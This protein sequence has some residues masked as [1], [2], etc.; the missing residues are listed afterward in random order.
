MKSRLAFTLAELL[1]VIAIMGLLMALILPAIQAARESGR[2]TV[3]ASNLAQLAKA[4][5]THQQARDHMP[6]YY[7]TDEYIRSQSAWYV[8]L[9]PYL[10]SYALYREM[11]GTDG[12][13]TDVITIPPTPPGPDCQP[14]VPG[15]WVATEKLQTVPGTGSSTTSDISI[16]RPGFRWQ[17]QKTEVVPPQKEWVQLDPPVEHPGRMSKVSNTRGY[18]KQAPVPAKG[19]CGS[20]G[21][22]K[23]S[24]TGFRGKFAALDMRFEVLL[25]PSDPDARALYYRKYGDMALTNYLA[26]VHAF[27]TGIT[28]P[29]SNQTTRPARMDAICNAD[30]LSNTIFFAEA[31]RICNPY[32][33]DWGVRFAFWS[34]R[35]HHTFGMDWQGRP[36]TYMFQ[37]RPAAAECNSWR[38]Q[39]MHGPELMVALGDGS[40]RPIS[41]AIARAER[42]DP[43]D[44]TPGAVI[45]WDRSY[46]PQAWDRAM[47]A[48]DHLPSGLE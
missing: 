43:D 3:C 38:M 23:K 5:H 14:P 46:E 25:C 28:D 45:D 41:S 47:L 12:E 21:S 6:P 9:L 30:G 8:F 27:T 36:N 24:R 34:D 48:Y 31:H 17:E 39:A 33:S 42:S 13:I 29:W 19:N 20:G 35:E 18:W 1:V 44:A 37:N 32:K 40:V 16:P 2:R 4:V 15:I 26:N 10:D 7:G 22:S 11:E